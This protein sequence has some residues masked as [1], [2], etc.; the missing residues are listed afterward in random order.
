M[1]ANNV[2]LPDR[3]LNRKAV[4]II[5]DDSSAQLLCAYKK[6]SVSEENRGKSVPSKSYVCTALQNERL[7]E[8][9][10]YDE[11]RQQESTC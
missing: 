11:D 8:S 7:P 5:V 2:I 3:G 10:A 1:K 9:V 4:V 6:A